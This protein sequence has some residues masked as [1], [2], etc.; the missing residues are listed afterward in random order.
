[1]NTLVWIST[2]VLAVIGLDQALLWAERQGWVYWRKTKGR[3]DGMGDVFLCVESSLNP[4]AENVLKAKETK[5]RD[6]R[7]A[8]DPPSLE[9]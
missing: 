2:I 6:D 1:M 8:G 4:R 9:S 7:A 3:R 5:R